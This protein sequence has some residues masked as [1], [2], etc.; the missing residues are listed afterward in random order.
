MQQVSFWALVFIWST[1]YWR[2]WSLKKKEK[3]SSGVSH[4]GGTFG[5]G[6]S[7]NDALVGCTSV[8]ISVYVFLCMYYCAYLYDCK[9][10][11]LPSSSTNHLY[12]SS[13]VCLFAPPTL[14]APRLPLPLPFLPPV[15]AALPLPVPLPLPPLLS[16]PLCCSTSGGCGVF[17]LLISITVI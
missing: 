13:G 11:H 16:H 12:R 1:K 10:P 7:V 17:R 2:R 14:P 6:C 3:Q 9:L 4:D 15:T 8:S 5:L